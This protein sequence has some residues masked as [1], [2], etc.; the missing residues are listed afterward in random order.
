MAQLRQIGLDEITRYVAAAAPDRS[1]ELAGHLA[2]I[3]LRGSA[4][5]HV[6]WYVQQQ[7]KERL[8]AHARA[9]RDLVVAIPDGPGRPDVLHHAD[10]VLAFYRGYVE[11][12]PDIRERFM[13]D[14][15]VAWQ[16]ETGHRVVFWGAN[17]HVAAAE[18]VEYEFPPTVPQGRLAPPVGH[19][20]RQE[21]GPGY[22]VIAAVFGSGAVLQGF[23][24]GRPQVYEVP[25]PRTGTLDSL[26]GQAT[27]ATLLLDLRAPDDGPAVREWLDGPAEMRLIGTAYDAAVDDRYAMRVA[28]LRAAF[29]AVV[30]VDRT[31]AARR[32]A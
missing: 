26:I 29:D 21:Y 2:E 31:D 17:V 28:S 13:A 9:V 11:G 15:L 12:A 5:E 22:A 23:E 19:L 30:Y 1:A 4:A 6:G 7:D 14:S 20:L 3:G 16:R 18:V 10:T 25:G 8:I 32:L 24:T 27:P